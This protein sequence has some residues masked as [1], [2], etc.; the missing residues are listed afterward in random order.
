MDM[1]HHAE[2][3][4]RLA[5]LLTKVLSSMTMWPHPDA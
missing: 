1:P 3:T 5:R 2:Q 4:K